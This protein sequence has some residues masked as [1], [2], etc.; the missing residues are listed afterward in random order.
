MPHGDVSLKTRINGCIVDFACAEHRL[1]VEVDGSQHARPGNLDHDRQRTL[2]L[3][4]DGW[5]VLRFWNDD[6]LR[7]VDDVCEHIVRGDREGGVRVMPSQVTPL[8]PAGHLPHKGRDQQAA[9]PRP[10][11]YLSPRPRD[12]VLSAIAMLSLGRFVLPA[13]LPPCGGDARQGRGGYRS[14][15]PACRP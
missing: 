1:I 8:C 14:L 12:V 6:V 15:P 13:D 7:D 11:T 9:M 10:A 5:T 3:E 4:A 2:G